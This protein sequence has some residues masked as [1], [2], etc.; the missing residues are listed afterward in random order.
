MPLFKTQSLESESETDSLPMHSKYI[1][2]V[3]T[4]TLSHDSSFGV[5][6]DDKDGSFKIWRSRFTYYNKDVF[7]DGKNYRAPQGLWQLLAK[8]KPDK[9]LV[10]FPDRQAYKKIYSSLIRIEIIIDPQAGSEQIKA[11]NIHG[12]FRECLRIVKYL[13]NRYNNAFG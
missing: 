13:G 4:R 6:Q 11:L 7:V 2:N 10:T 3:L 1:D 12:L 5:Y 9:N 8:S